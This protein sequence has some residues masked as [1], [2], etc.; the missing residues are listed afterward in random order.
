MPRP[1]GFLHAAHLLAQ[2]AQ[3]PRGGQPPQGALRRRRQGHRRQRRPQLHPRGGDHQAAR[4]GGPRLLGGHP[5]LLLAQQHVG[6][7]GH[8]GARVQRDLP[9]GGGMRHPVLR[10]GPEDRAGDGGQILQVQVPVLL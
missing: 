5:L 7:V 8:A 3:L 2:D 4:Q 9:G 1:V 6:L 10:Q